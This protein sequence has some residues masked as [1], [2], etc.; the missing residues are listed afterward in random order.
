VNLGSK[1]KSR[2]D[3]LV[4]DNAFPVAAIMEDQDLTKVLLRLSCCGHSCA[5]RRSRSRGREA[6]PMG[7][8]G[9][10]PVCCAPSPA[11][12]VDSARA[13]GENRSGSQTSDRGTRDKL[14]QDGRPHQAAAEQESVLQDNKHGGRR[15]YGNYE[16]MSA[17]LSNPEHQKQ[18]VIILMSRSQAVVVPALARLWRMQPSE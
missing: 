2:E 17:A 1:R 5:G 3:Y 16:T 4:G 6:S 8:Y 11:D 13:A 10:H 14:C 7:G 9:H 12:S 18:G 15:S